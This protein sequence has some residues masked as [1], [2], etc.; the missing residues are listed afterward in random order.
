MRPCQQ[1]S[2]E[3]EVVDILGTALSGGQQASEDEVKRYLPGLRPRQPLD[4]CLRRNLVTD[5]QHLPL[6]TRDR[7][8]V[9]AITE[10]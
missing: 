9:L 3:V 7:R 5:Q 8:V 10:S 2:A 6:R 1:L 4:R